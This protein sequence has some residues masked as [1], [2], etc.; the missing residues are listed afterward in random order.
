MSNPVYTHT[1]THTRTHTH[2]YIYIYIY[3]HDLQTHFVDNILKRAW[4]LF[5]HTVKCFQVLRY[6]SRNLT[7]VICLHTVGSIWPIDMT[8]SGA[9]TLGLSRPDSNGNEGVYHIPQISKLQASPSDCSMTYPGH[10]LADASI[11]PRLRC[12]RCILQPRTTGLCSWW[13]RKYGFMHFSWG[14]VWSEPI[15]YKQRFE[16]GLPILIFVPIIVRRTSP[17]TALRHIYSL[18]VRF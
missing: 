12:Y 4:T 18:S 3:I 17:C 6:S 9:T 16:L 7:S 8:L 1:H 2:I 14:L 13:W 10:W 15:L 11:T 5:L